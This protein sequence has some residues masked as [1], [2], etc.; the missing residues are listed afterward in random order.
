MS[1]IKNILGSFFGTKSGRDLKAL[2]PIID[3][4]QKVSPTIESLSDDGLRAKT[5]EFQNK[6]NQAVS[7]QNLEIEKIQTALDKDEI[8][9]TKKE[10]SYKKIDELK[11][12]AYDRSEEV[13]LDILPE[14]FA[15]VKETSRRLAQNKELK[16][17]AQDFDKDL[18]SEFDFVT[19]DGDQAIWSNKWLAFGAEQ[20]WNMVHYDVQLIGG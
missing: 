6:I 2:K 15:V 13:L 11:K 19:I 7:E 9:I 18:A 12:Q 17:T 20:I 14:A 4:V 5:S 8:E 16:V 10:A 1:I 3:K